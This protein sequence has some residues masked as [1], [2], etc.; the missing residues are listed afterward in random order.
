[1]GDLEQARAMYEQ[2][3]AAATQKGDSHTRAEIE[4]ALHALPSS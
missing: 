2:G 3:I 4:A 1:M